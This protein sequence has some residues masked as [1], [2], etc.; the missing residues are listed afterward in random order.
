[1]IEE[2]LMKYK[3]QQAQGL[4]SRVSSTK[5]NYSL[6]L[7]QVNLGYIVYTGSN[8]VNDTYVFSNKIDL[9]KHLEMLIPDIDK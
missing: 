8:F 1:M 6:R 2:D 9:L 4:M 7:E 5:E 3:A